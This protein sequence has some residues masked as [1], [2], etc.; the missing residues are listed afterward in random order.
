M[1]PDRSHRARPPRLRADEQD[2]GGLCRQERWPLH[3]SVFRIIHYY[4]TFVIFRL[5]LTR[6]CDRNQHFVLF[7]Q[8]LKIQYGKILISVYLCSTFSF[9]ISS[10]PARLAAER[11][12]H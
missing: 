12:K 7:K 8:Q 6:Q 4:T 10:Q 9:R 2:G 5:I 11:S 1:S 3:L